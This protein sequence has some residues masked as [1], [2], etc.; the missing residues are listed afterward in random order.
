MDGPLKPFYPVVG[1]G[2]EVR[3]SFHE[4]GGIIGPS[5]RTTYGPKGMFVGLQ[6]RIGLSMQI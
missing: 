6:H 5:F 1:M 4:I 3:G 2:L